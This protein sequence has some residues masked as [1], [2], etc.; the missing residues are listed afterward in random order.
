MEGLTFSAGQKPISFTAAPSNFQ[1]PS[2]GVTYNSS[3][4]AQNAARMAAKQQGVPYSFSGNTIQPQYTNS[5]G[6]P[7]QNAREAVGDSQLQQL[8]KANR[9]PVQ[10]FEYQRLLRDLQGQQPDI[11]KQ[12]NDIYNP[13]FDYLNQAS[14]N[15][16]K[17]YP[18]I[19]TEIGQTYDVSKQNLDINKQSNVRDIDNS[20]SQGERRKEDALIAARR[21]FNELST[22][23]LQ[24]FGGASTA[25]EAYQALA[26]RELQR[27]VQSAQQ[28]FSDF[29]GQVTTARTK[30]NEQYTQSLNTLEL[31]KNQALSNARRE[32]DSKMLEITRLKSQAESEKASRRLDALQTLRNQIFQINLTSAEMRSQATSQA[33]SAASE[34]DNAIQTFSQQTGAANQ[35]GQSFAQNQPTSYQSNLMSTNYQNPTQNLSYT[36]QINPQRDDELFRSTFA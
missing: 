22:G 31:Q 30:L 4:D 28:Q 6:Q 19:Q 33:Q 3:T 21:L 34:L 29:M 9:N 20:Q 36:G 2:A 23:G 32:F 26:G 16:E 27:N 14:S 24:R 8:A 17:D 10:E 25:G 18:L 1:I 15:I 7:V 5:A 11:E 12:I 35:A 13:T